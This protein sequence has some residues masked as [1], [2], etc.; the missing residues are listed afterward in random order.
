[1]CLASEV[2]FVHHTNT[3]D[4]RCLLFGIRNEQSFPAR[5]RKLFWKRGSGAFWVLLVN[6]RIHCASQFT[7]LLTNNRVV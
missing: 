6:Q 2:V 5:N 4:E 1:M 7:P 3:R